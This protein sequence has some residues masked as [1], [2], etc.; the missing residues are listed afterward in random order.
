MS[1]HVI[2]GLPRSGSTLL[3]NV[4]DQREDVHVSATSCL[5]AVLAHCSRVWTEAPELKSELIR[6]R[7]TT[8]A[9]MRY[10]L[11]GLVNGWYHDVR[12]RVVFDKSRL[13]NHHVR[14]LEW[15]YPDAHMIVVV[16][17]LRSVLASLEKQHARTAI[18][19]AANTPQEK[20]LFHRSNGYFSPDGL[21]GSCIDGVEDMLRRRPDNVHFVRY[22]D[23]V[24]RPKTTLRELYEDIGMTDF[25]HDF[26]DVKNTTGTD[27]DGLYLHKFP[28]YG[29]GK[30]EERADEWERWV[31]DD[32]SQQLTAK[33]RGYNSAFKYDGQ[34]TN[35]N[36]YSVGQNGR[37]RLSRSDG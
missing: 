27:V 8:E 4:I 26:D 34:V 18:F 10:A 30:V 17:D 32:L 14:L 28:H 6:N 5:P 36:N 15:L 33:Y 2:C 22:E 29:E 25:E 3:A 23:F 35:G 13:W 16:R 24:K 31:S 7:M 12:D 9:R 21:V 1:F 37:Q 11:H 20:T 19:D